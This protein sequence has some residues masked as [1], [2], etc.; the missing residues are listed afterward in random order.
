MDALQTRLR[1]L[2][3]Q[4][5]RWQHIPPHPG[6]VERAVTEMNS[7]LLLLSQQRGG[8]VQVRTGNIFPL[9]TRAERRTGA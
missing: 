3:D 7:I 8:P 4:I 2:R 6:A 9:P 5:A 1:A